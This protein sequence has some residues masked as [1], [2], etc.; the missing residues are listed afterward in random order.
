MSVRSQQLIESHPRGE[1]L[2]RLAQELVRKKLDI[3]RVS[4]QMD[5]K[6]TFQPSLT[7]K[8]KQMR[9][10]TSFERSRG[11]LIRK[12][13]NHRMRRLRS[14]QEELAEMTFQP[15]IT[16]LANDI[17]KSHLNLNDDPSGFLERHLEEKFEKEEKRKKY[18]LEQE[19]KEVAECTFV[20]QT[21]DCPAYI[22]RIAK[23]LSIVKANRSST[24]NDTDSKPDWK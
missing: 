24:L 15:K 21:I 6:C 18:L 7:K 20:P 3:Q 22:K 10:R 8:S 14:E 16:K 23:S 9:A 12:E 5:A 17:G 11:D 13:T 1:F 19:E 4:A 2:D